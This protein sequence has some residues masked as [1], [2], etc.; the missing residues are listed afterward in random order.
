MLIFL[1]FCE[2]IVGLQIQK[3]SH[4]LSHFCVRLCVL[5][6]GLCAC[7]SVCVCVCVM[8]SWLGLQAFSTGTRWP[9][10]SCPSFLLSFLTPSF[11][12]LALLCAPQGRLS[13]WHCC[14]LL[15]HP[16][17]PTYLIHT[18]IHT[19]SCLGE[20]SLSQPVCTL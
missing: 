6:V 7:I 15:I 1:H 10:V 4:M 12:A 5:F 16:L 9:I 8:T 13:R 2:R 19:H 11:H 17:I 14:R 3:V 18:H 20:D